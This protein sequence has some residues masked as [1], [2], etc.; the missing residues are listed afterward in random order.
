MR[1]VCKGHERGRSVKKIEWTP[2]LDFKL[3][4][5]IDEGWTYRSIAEKMG[6][7]VWTVRARACELG[8]RHSDMLQAVFSLNAVTRRFFLNASVAGVLSWVERGWLGKPKVRRSS[9]K[10]TSYRFTREQLEAFLE[11]EEGWVAWQPEDLRDSDL[12]AWA[13]EHR[14]AAGWT[15]VR[16]RDAMCS[17][18]YKPDYV[19][20]LIA[21]GAIDASKCLLYASNWWIRSDEVERFRATIPDRGQVTLRRTYGEPVFS[22]RVT[23]TKSQIRFFKTW[24]GD[25][26]KGVRAVADHLMNQSANTAAD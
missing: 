5:H 4:R 25:L 22:K 13:T 3:T 1:V 18:N 23:L 12:R 10:R 6:L 24:G 11:V 9:A 14:A 8:I 21:E 17:M 19:G 26:A 16:G 20:I 7:S 2:V 15:W